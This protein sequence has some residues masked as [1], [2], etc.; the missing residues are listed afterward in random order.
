MERLSYNWAAMEIL[1]IIETRIK[2]QFL[3]MESQSGRLRNSSD[4]NTE[5]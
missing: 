2:K 5:I 1:L 4:I 3:V